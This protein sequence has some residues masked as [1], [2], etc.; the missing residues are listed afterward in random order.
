[1]KRILAAGCRESLPHAASNSPDNPPSENESESMK[2][3]QCQ[4]PSPDSAIRIL[5]IALVTLWFGSVA[6]PGS[7][8]EERPNE[9]IM[10][11]AEKEQQPTKVVVQ[12]N[13]EFAFDLYGQLS[14]ETADKNLF[15]SPYSI[16]TALAMVAE[17]ARGETALEMGTTLHFP[18]QARRVGDDA[19]SMPWQTTMIHS[20]MAQLQDRFN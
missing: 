1:M 5:P 9:R 13:S 19:Q 18:Q 16:S 8:A 7:Q 6:L 17:G 10:P 15:F 14:K 4:S 3:I 2:S 20:G 11:A 12:A